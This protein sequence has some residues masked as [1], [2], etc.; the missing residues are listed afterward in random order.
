[1]CH[2]IGQAFR[3]KKARERGHVDQEWE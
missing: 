3:T 2:F 1:V